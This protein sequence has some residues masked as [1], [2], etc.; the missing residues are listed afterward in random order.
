MA[1]VSRVFEQS[2]REAILK[3]V[4]GSDISDAQ[5]HVPWH[6]I[7][8]HEMPPMMLQLRMANGEILSY[9]YSDIRQIRMRDAGYVQLFV[10]GFTRVIVTLEG[11]LLQSLAND[12]GGGMIHWIQEADERDMDIPENRPSIVSIQIELCPEE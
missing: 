12:I 9:S 2:R 1:Q 8:A 6:R 5:E 11:R 7:Q 4:P 3:T 10:A